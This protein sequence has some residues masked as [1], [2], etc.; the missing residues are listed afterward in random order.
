[1]PDDTT[2]QVKYDTVPYEIYKNIIMDAIPERDFIGITLAHAL[3]EPEFPGGHKEFIRFVND[4]LIFPQSMAD[5]MDSEKIFC[6][7]I[8]D[9]IGKARLYSLTQNRNKVLPTKVKTLIEAL[10]LFTPG[11]SKR[12]KDNFII[13][14]I[15]YFTKD[16][17]ALNTNDPYFIPVF[18]TD[19][20]EYCKFLDR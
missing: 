15:F 9:S 11:E 5:T 13:F 3:K 6:D 1:M 17:N 8:I 2:A 12:G 14:A 19:N 18:P 16:T 10:P 7:I 4:N 20:P